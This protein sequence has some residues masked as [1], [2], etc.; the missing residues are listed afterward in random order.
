VTGAALFVLHEQ[1]N[2]NEP[3]SLIDDFVL[4]EVYHH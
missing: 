2:D 4:E 1:V 3:K